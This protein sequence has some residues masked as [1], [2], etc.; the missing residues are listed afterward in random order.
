M[1]GISTMLDPS[2]SGIFLRPFDV[3]LVFA[4]CR[5]GN[6]SVSLHVS[7]RSSKSLSGLIN[8]ITVNVDIFVQLNL[9]ASSLRR[10]FCATKLLRR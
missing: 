8:V 9:Y 5:G 3:E 10:R 4:G 7:N 6:G 1:L 2:V